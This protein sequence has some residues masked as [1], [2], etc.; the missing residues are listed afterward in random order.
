MLGLKV[1]RLWLLVATLCATSIRAE[2]SILQAGG[3]FDPFLLALQ[4]AVQMSTLPPW[5]SGA[6]KVDPATS[7]VTVTIHPDWVS[8]GVE[9][10]V[11]T[12]V[13]TDNGDGG[14]ALEWESDDAKISTISYGL[15]EI[16]KPVGLN[17]RTVLLPET[18]TRKGGKLLLSYFGKFDSLLSLAIRPAR[19]DTL[20]VIG[21]RQSP[22]LI[23]GNLQVFEDGEVNG[24]RPIPLAGD[25]RNGSIIEAELSARVE[26]LDEPLEFIIPIQGKPEAGMLRLESL[27]LDPEAKIEVSV[28]GHDLGPVNFPS[29]QLDD[30][31]LVTD[32]N[33]NIILA[34]WRKGSLF[35]AARHLL[36]GENSISLTLKRSNAE[37]GRE[38]F[39]RNSG[40]H[41]RFGTPEWPKESAGQAIETNVD[42]LMTEPDFSLAEPAL[43]D[44]PA[45]EPV[46]P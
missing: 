5:V 9:M 42:G 3:T 44:F 45:T 4:P 34:G 23:D 8:S 26:A 15:G 7:T 12:I 14:P 37:T 38:V 1:A 30:P 33:G 17:S 22:V 39:L 27:G 36:E 6:P 10:F 18:L 20:A 40:I 46:T 32:W 2:N 21:E 31:S 24:T 19:E 16:G 13:F 35:I 43:P 29:F 11:A 41:L 28:N 25:I